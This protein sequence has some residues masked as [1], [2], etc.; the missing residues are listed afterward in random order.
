MSI[1]FYGSELGC[2]R[3]LDDS[4]DFDQTRTG[5][6]CRNTFDFINVRLEC[7][8]TIP[9]TVMYSIRLITT[10]NKTRY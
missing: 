1:A 6:V 8:T 5:Y 2:S 3:L 4:C 7:P 10:A 9:A